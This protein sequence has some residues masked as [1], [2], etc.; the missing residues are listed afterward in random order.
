VR[1]FI[2]SFLALP[3]ALIVGAAPVAAD[4]TGGGSG[5]HFGSFTETCSTSGGRQV[6]TDTSLSVDPNGDGTSSACL[7]IFTYSQS[8]NG[9]F[10]F[11]SDEFGCTSNVSLT[12]G[13]DYSVTLASTVIPMETCQAHKRNCSGSS[14]V[15]V[16]ASDQ[17]VG[18]ISKSTTRSTTISGGCTYRTTIN[19]TFGEVAGTM[20]IDG[21]TVAENG[22]LDIIDESST[23]RCK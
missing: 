11:I 22:Y 21:T 19:E 17:L 10:T 12:V 2:I 6:C 20:T 16:S 5:T 4:T 23:V 3:I 13:S 15:T 7:D 1:R 8:S 14:D 9:R 18:D